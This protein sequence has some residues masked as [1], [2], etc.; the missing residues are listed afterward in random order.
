[1][2][3]LTVEAEGHLRELIAHYEAHDR[4]EAA[5]NLLAA[6]TEAQERI[7]ANP[8]AGLPA[9]RPYPDLK[10]PGRLWLKAGRYWVAYCQNPLVI[11]GVFYEMAD[12]PGR[13]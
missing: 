8:G 5:R 1:M 11:T 13:I 10:K 9:P 6:L 12:I 2:V 7:A 3:S 4:L